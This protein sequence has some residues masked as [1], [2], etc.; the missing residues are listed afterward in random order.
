M[1]S[2]K[3]A[4]VVEAQPAWASAPATDNATAK[5]EGS[6]LRNAVK[7]AT[8][9]AADFMAGRGSGL[10]RALD[11]PLSVVGAAGSYLVPHTGSGSFYDRMAQTDA[12]LKRTRQESQARSPIAFS[13]GEVTQALPISTGLNYASE[14]A[15][16]RGYKALDAVSKMLGRAANATQ[17]PVGVEALSALPMAFSRMTPAAASTAA[18]AAAGV[19]DVASLGGAVSWLENW[20]NQPT[21]HALSAALSPANFLG[22]AHPAAQAAPDAAQY[23]RDLGNAARTR[24]MFPKNV[25]AQ[26]A[27]RDHFGT[28]EAAGEAL[29]T[30]PGGDLTAADL[31]EQMRADRV[32]NAKRT[33]GE[34]IGDIRQQA[35]NADAEVDANDVFSRVLQAY[36][37]HFGGAANGATPSVFRSKA[38][39]GLELLKSIK[40]EF[41][42]KYEPES[43]NVSYD[44]EHPALNYPDTK[45][46]PVA[47][48][49]KGTG[50][51]IPLEVDLADAP[52]TPFETEVTLNRGDALVTNGVETWPDASLSKSP[53]GMEPVTPGRPPARAEGHITPSVKRLETGTTRPAANTGW[54]VVFNDL[55]PATPNSPV[56]GTSTNVKFKG[57]PLSTWTATKKVYG[58][59]VNN[60]KGMYPRPDANIKSDPWLSFLDDVNGIF[61]AAEDAAVAKSVPEKAQRYQSA[62]TNYGNAST[63]EQMAQHTANTAAADVSPGGSSRGNLAPDT[64]PHG[65]IHRLTAK[66]SDRTQLNRANRNA[67]FADWW[68]SAFPTPDIQNVMSY[69]LRNQENQ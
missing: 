9:T 13:S 20:N 52:R 48:T 58:D 23:W 49:H 7:Y 30:F 10:L 22:L 1:P 24:I 17:G 14:V 40:E 55:F 2:W 56:E 61:A 18:R 41:S 19:A 37:R 35:V 6:V 69:Y 50:A 42:P 60:M 21:Q 11:L 59:I 25:Q 3:N 39:K 29:R 46:G 51:T 15:G 43:T 26:G 16:G 4:P 64:T 57:Q 31:T 32:S 33:E 28:Q 65:W 53:A 45:N 5:K 27:L 12:G 63:L 68:G 36:S 8:E 38:R 67:A 66:P 47:I 34:V 44:V 54:D 62:K